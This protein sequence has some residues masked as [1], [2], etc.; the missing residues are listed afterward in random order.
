MQQER[1][2]QTLFTEMRTLLT[3][4]PRP[5]KQ[6]VDHTFHSVYLFIKGKDWKKAVDVTS[7]KKV[8]KLLMPYTYNYWMPEYKFASRLSKAAE[9]EYNEVRSI[10]RKEMK[11]LLDTL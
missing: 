6:C 11:E 3:E 5:Y 9:A 2:Y 7:A 1:Q 8:E 10:I 4:T